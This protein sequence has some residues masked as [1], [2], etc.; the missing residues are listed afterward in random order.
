MGCGDAA[1]LASIR[2]AER[3]GAGDRQNEERQNRRDV[4]PHAPSIR[5]KFVNICRKTVRRSIEK[6]LGAGD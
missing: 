6:L 1:S 5:P 2:T 3:I 4:N